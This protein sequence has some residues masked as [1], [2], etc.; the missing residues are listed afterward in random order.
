[1][2]TGQEVCLGSGTLWFLRDTAR[3]PPP[4]PEH[5][6]RTGSVFAGC[7]G[8]LQGDFHFMALI[9]DPGGEDKRQLA[10]GLVSTSTSRPWSSTGAARGPSTSRAR[11]VFAVTPHLWPDRRAGGGQGGAG[12]GGQGGRCVARLVITDTQR[13]CARPH[14]S[15][16]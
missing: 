5:R 14:C 6:G 3:R 1:M 7:V 13:R 10:E 2:G 11:W 4:P 16:P 9:V 15:A 12:A 8:F